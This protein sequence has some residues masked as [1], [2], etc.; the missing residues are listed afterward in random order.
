MGARPG[1]IL[2]MVVRQGVVLVFLGLVV[3][4][5]LTLA[6]GRLVASLLYQIRP[7][8]PV[9]LTGAAF[10]LFVVALLACVTP[11]IR[12]SRTAPAEALRSE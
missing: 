7:A 9:A 4:L 2:R 10:L 1:D 3:G 6:G 12:A 8:D 5:A 11:A